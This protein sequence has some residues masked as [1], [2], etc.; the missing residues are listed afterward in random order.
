MPHYV[1]F[2]IQVMQRHRRYMASHHLCHHLVYKKQLPAGTKACIKSSSHLPLGPPAFSPSSQNSPGRF[3][4]QQP[5]C[6]APQQHILSDRPLQSHAELQSPVIRS[7]KPSCYTGHAYCHSHWCCCSALRLRWHR[8]VA[9]SVQGTGRF[10][11]CSCMLPS[12]TCCHAVPAASLGTA[13]EM[14]YGPCF[15]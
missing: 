8:Q 5:S 11:E 6:T 3:P 9:G 12:L 15:A 4:H 10:L 13:S 7:A 14:Y 2:W 1:I